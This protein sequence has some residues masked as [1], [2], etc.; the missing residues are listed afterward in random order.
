M[1]SHSIVYLMYPPFRPCQM[2]QESCRSCNY[3]PLGEDRSTE[4]IFGICNEPWIGLHDRHEGAVPG[5]ALADQAASGELPDVIGSLFGSGW[6]VLI[7]A[8]V[9]SDV[10]RVAGADHVLVEV[11]A[12]RELAALYQRFVITAVHT[13]AP[14][15]YCPNSIRPA[16]AG[17]TGCSV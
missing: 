13:D 14:G 9:V 7:D 2:A 17:L 4:E 10:A 16:P 3:I 8:E 11:A 1:P 15:W 6:S 5:H 12:D